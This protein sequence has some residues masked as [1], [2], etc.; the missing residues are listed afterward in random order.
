MGYYDRYRGTKRKKQQ[1]KL[2]MISIVLLFLIIV[3][4]GLLVLGDHITYSADGFHFTWGDPPKNDDK[5]IELPKDDPD[6]DPDYV[7]GGDSTSPDFALTQGQTGSKLM[8]ANQ[9]MMLENA[10]PSPLNG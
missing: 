1:R 6:D 8:D 7:I 10:L 2:L 5:P 3:V 4:V 9:Y